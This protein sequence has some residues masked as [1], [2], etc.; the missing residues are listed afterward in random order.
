[1]LYYPWEVSFVMHHYHTTLMKN[2]VCSESCHKKKEGRNPLFSFIK[3][4]V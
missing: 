1:M 3:A 2:W 4:L